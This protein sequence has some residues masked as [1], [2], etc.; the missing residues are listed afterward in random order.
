MGFK[1]SNDDFLY[2]LSTFIYEPIRWNV[3]FG[4]RLMCEQE[5]LASF[6]FW[7]EVG[8]RMHIQ[9]IPETYEDL[10]RYNL[11]YEQQHF[12]YSDT[13]RR[14]GEA[15]RDLFLSWFPR[16]LQPAIAPAIYALLDDAIIE[17]CGLPKAPK[18]LCSGLAMSLRLR[19]NILRFFPPRQQPDFFTDS[20]VRS[21]PSGYE[22]SKL[23]SASI[24]EQ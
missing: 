7:R 10:E 18:I 22:I 13:N 15:T 1:I 16:I 5:R 19:G 23:G 24:S 3:R 2:V 17:A 9:D 4:W 8:Q 21:Y 11:D 6:Y 12:R 14:I 20:P